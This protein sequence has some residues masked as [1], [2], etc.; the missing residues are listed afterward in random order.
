MYFSPR[1]LMD[2]IRAC[3]A[4]DRGSTPLEGTY[5]KRY[6]LVYLFY[7]G[8]SKGVEGAGFPPDDG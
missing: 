8:H 7:I 6:T 3:G 4:C 5:L 1:S 2:R